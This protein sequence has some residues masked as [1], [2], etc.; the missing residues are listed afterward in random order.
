MASF[1]YIYDGSLLSDQNI[2]EIWFS[3]IIILVY[4]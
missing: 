2:D 1:P 4:I 3:F